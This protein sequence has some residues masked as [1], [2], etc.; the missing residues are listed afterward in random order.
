MN[1]RIELN[2]LQLKTFTEQD[3]LDYCFLNNINLDYIEELDLSHNELTD[4]SG[5]KLFKNLKKLYLNINRLSNISGIKDL[6][7]LEWLNISNNKIKNILVLKNLIKLEILNISY[8][9]IKDISVLKNLIKLKSLD[10]KDLKLESDQIQ[11]IK[12]LKKLK[13]LWKD[14][15]FKDMNILKQLNKNIRIIK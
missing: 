14:N 11:Y 9:K 13:I 4:I 1:K 5:V 12:S 7:N 2:D 10:I 6:I 15:G 8:N 3:V